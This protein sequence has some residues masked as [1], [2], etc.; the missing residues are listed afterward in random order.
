VTIS[1]GN[2]RSQ[3]QRWRAR[4]RGD[5][6]AF[7]HALSVEGWTRHAFAHALSVE[8]WT[9]HAIRVASQAASGQAIVQLGPD[10]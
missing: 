4:Y 5:A 7:A 8:G 9:R 6:H 2:T 1:K 10:E 3:R